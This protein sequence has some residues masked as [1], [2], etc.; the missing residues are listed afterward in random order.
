MSDQQGFC[1]EVKFR[2]YWVLLPSHWFIFPTMLKAETHGKQTCLTL[3]TQH[4]LNSCGFFP[5]KTHWINSDIQEWFQ[6]TL[7]NS[8]NYI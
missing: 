4:I 6:T 5:I 2:R 8:E 1:G 3:L 7:N